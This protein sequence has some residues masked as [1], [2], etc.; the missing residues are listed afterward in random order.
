LL[1]QD[2]EHDDF[3][4]ALAA[5]VAGMLFA[6]AVPSLPTKTIQLIEQWLLDMVPFVELQ[7]SRKFALSH[8]LTLPRSGRVTSHVLRHSEERPMPTCNGDSIAGA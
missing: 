8:V 1:A 7:V 2:G 4:E 3:G 6:I 5:G